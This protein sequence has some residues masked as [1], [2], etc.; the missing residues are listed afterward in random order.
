MSSLTPSAAARDGADPIFALHA[1]AVRRARAGESILNA[2]LGALLH[3]DGRLAVM[4][5]A[6]EAFARVPSDIAAAYAPIAGDPAFLEAV[7]ADVFEAESLAEQAV[8]VATPGCTGAL[9]AAV[10]DFLEPGEAALT[11][12]HFWGSYEAIT[13]YTGRGIETFNMFRP[14]LRF[15]T[16]AFASGLSAT[17]DR[18]A[19]AL[20]LFNFPCHNPTGYS[21]DDG[22]WDA[23]SSIVRD[24]GARAPVAFMLDN[25]YAAF[26]S[27][28]NRWVHYAPRMLETATVLVGWT[29]SKT[30]TQYG[31]RV[32]ALVAAHRDA[33]ERRK[34]AGALSFSCRATWSNCNQPGLLAATALL[35]DPQLRRRSTEERERLI[36]LLQERVEAFNDAAHAAGLAYPRYEGG[37]F[38]T[39]FTPDGE[40]TAATM[41]EA[42]VFVLP[43]AG[44]VRVALCA[45]PVAEISRLVDAL[46]AGVAAA[47]ASA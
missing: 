2:T 32:G 14:D 1:E 44:A 37:F 15:D 43:M 47:E 27:G 25:A 35:T 20:V 23:V 3:D 28:G 22:E 6:A 36:E 33:A 4:P 7:I 8:A 16:D 40:V 29:I 17:L 10:V 13:S 21:L 9:H 24:A 18:Q 31:A 12:S 30:F 38:V 26:G 11:T 5:S 46:A 45:T 39:V 19:R 42:G 34:L 41:R